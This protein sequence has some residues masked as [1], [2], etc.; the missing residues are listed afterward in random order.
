MEFIDLKKIT[1]YD[2]FIAILSIILGKRNSIL[3]VGGNVVNVKLD[4]GGELLLH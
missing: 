3:F 1:R 4:K 2:S